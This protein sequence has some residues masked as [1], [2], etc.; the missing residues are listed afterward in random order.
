TVVRPAGRN[1]EL[2]GACGYAVEVLELL[3]ATEA[4]LVIVGAILDGE[5]RVLRDMPAPP[6]RTSPD[7]RTMRDRV[8]RERFGELV[9]AGSRM[10]YDALI[11]HVVASLQAVQDPQ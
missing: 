4:A 1:A 2:D 3:G 6:S 9:T 11:D 8:G 5:L 10:T 7:V